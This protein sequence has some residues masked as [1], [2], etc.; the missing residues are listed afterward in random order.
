VGINYDRVLEDRTLLRDLEPEA[1]RR[2]LA[3]SLGIFGRFA[4]R[5]A[6]LRLRRRWYRFGYACVCFGEPISVRRWLTE[7]QVD[8]RRL[9][10]EERF[11][12][13]G[14]IAADLMEAVRT[15]IPVLPVALV[16]DVVTRSPER[17]WSELELKAAVQR[18]IAE[19]EA[20]GRQVY[21][22]RKDRDYAIEV[23]LR[24]LV[25]RHLVIERDGLFAPVPAE[26]PL[27]AYYAHS[28]G[29]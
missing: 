11:G 7:R 25:L 21:V 12:V 4:L 22:P 13:V 16:A 9:P 26:L 23:G 18:R 15:S 27:L 29:E 5:Q 17:A 14:E 24:M 3:A 8:L 19:L 28:I 2:G 1:S 10:R 6:A 20:A